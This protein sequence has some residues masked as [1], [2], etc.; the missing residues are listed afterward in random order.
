M[1]FG[2]FFDFDF[3]FGIRYSFFSYFVFGAM[4]YGRGSYGGRG[5][6]R[7]GGRGGRGGYGDR[8]YN[9]GPPDYVERTNTGL[10]WG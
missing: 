2:F 9:Q 4:S 5:G 6:S 7:G 1:E 8:S 10:A 3:D